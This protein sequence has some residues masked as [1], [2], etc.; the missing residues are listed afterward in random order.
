MLYLTSISY[1]SASDILTQNDNNYAQIRLTKVAALEATI[2]EL[3]SSVTHL[4][5]ELISANT[6][7]LSLQTTMLSMLK[8]NHLHTKTEIAA[9]HNLTSNTRH[10]YPQHSGLVAGF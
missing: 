8:N 3:Q 9:L 4:Q 10:N 7:L 2:K 1:A 5:K 6:S